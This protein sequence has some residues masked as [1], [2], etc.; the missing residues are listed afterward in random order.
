MAKQKPTL[1]P[2]GKAYVYSTLANS[3]H[4]TDYKHGPHDMP[5]KE[6]SVFVKGGTGIASK[7][8]IT[9]RG[10]VTEVSEEDAQFLERNHHF[11]EHAKRGFVSIERTYVEPEKAAS[12]M[13]LNDPSAPLTPSD[14]P[15][16]GENEVK[17]PKV[18]K[19]A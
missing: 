18:G 5:I 19:V 17:E 6:H 16:T 4:Y 2:T 14:Y 9:P 7:H 15:G 1:K 12:D 8:L 13:D 11:Q 10:V 3:Q